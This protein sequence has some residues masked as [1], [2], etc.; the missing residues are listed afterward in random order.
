MPLYKLKHVHTYKP[1]GTF[2]ELALQYDALRGARIVTATDCHFATVSRKDYTRVLARFKEQDLHRQM[3][4]LMKLPFLMHMSKNQISKLMQVTTEV[5]FGKGQ[6]VV[7]EATENQDI[8]F[9]KQGEFKGY[10]HFRQPVRNDEGKQQRSVKD[11]LLGV[12]AK[13]SVRGV[14]NSKISSLTPNQALAQKMS[15]ARDIEVFNFGTGQVF[16]EERQMEFATQKH[17]F[18]SEGDKGSA[19]EGCPA[20]HHDQLK[21]SDFLAPFKVVCASGTGKLVKIPLPEFQRKLLKDS[22]AFRLLQQNAAEKQR[23]SQLRINNYL[24]DLVLKQNS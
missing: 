16:G 18:K 3:D 7:G 2:G 13:R 1:G 21:E 14:F 6:V 24:K 11:F 12:T 15:V 8:F 10:K 22:R 20:H 23:N 19:K 4:Y 17:S 9:V 5:T